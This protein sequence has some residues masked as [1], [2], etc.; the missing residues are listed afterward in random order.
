MCR[1]NDENFDRP[2]DCE[3]KPHK[4]A[5][6][7]KAW[8]DGADIEVR[9]TTNY[10]SKAGATLAPWQSVNDLDDVVWLDEWE[11]R[12]KPTPKPDIHVF[13]KLY[14]EDYAGE[15][16]A[17]LVNSTQLEANIKV[18]LDGETNKLKDVVIL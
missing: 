15:H 16:L 17:R 11:Y 5:T 7:I 1:C 9:C 2:C 10:S 3:P 18:M 6:L 8:A 14:Y 12:I 13:A 4:H